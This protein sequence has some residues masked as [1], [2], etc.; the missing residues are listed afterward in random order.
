MGTF[1]A[2]LLAAA[3]AAQAPAEAPAPE[4]PDGLLVMGAV[5]RDD[6]AS[7]VH[8]E[9]AMVA[10]PRTGA[11]R[12]RLLPGGTL[13]YSEVT[14]V[15]DRVLYAGH[16]GR[17]SVTLTLPLTLTGA[18]RSLGGTGTVTPSATPGRLWL[19]RWHHGRTSTLATLREVELEGE[20]VSRTS[21]RLPR[22]SGVVAATAGGF[23]ISS[24]RDLTLWDRGLERPLRRIRDRWLIAAGSSSFAWCGPRCGTL[25]VWSRDGERR[26]EPPAGIRVRIGEGALSPDGSRLAVPV[27]HEGGSRV[28]VLDIAA[29]SWTV[30]PGGGLHGYEAMAWSPSGRWLYFTGRGRRLLAWRPGSGHA[31]RLPADPGGTVMSISTTGYPGLGASGPAP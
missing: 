8:G 21:G 7:A 20:A 31:V 2:L 1:L 28:G 9:R 15:G 17:R 5:G 16:R 30:V 29:R 11:V 22:W 3:G 26:F 23:L 27:T 6:S 24:G 18:P 13:C 10:D 25:R 14:A 12:A 19:G 4:A